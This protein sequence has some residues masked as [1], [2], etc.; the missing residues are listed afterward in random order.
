MMMMLQL[1]LF[2][3]IYFRGK[4]HQTQ[5]QNIIAYGTKLKNKKT[6]N[7]QTHSFRRTTLF[8][9]FFTQTPIQLPQKCL[10]INIFSYFI[11]FHVNFYIDKFVFLCVCTFYY[12]GIELI[13][14][15]KLTSDKNNETNTSNN[16]TLLRCVPHK[17]FDRQLHSIENQH[18]IHQI[19]NKM[20]IQFLRF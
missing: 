1:V 14:C 5:I 19:N 11:F 15:T 18:I 4:I 8:F 10:H 20:C 16:N 7:I 9:A 17:L 12:F 13:M 2:K 3:F 6:T